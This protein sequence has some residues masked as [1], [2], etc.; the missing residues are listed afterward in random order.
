MRKTKSVSDAISL[1]N[2][3]VRAT[4]ESN[5]QIFRDTPAYSFLEQYNSLGRFLE[6][7]SYSCAPEDLIADP[8]EFLPVSKRSEPTHG[9][10]YGSGYSGKNKAVYF[11][12]VDANISAK[13]LTSIVRPCLYAALSNH[14]ILLIARKRDNAIGS[15]I[16][17]KVFPKMDV[18]TT[19]FADVS[20]VGDAVSW[21]NDHKNTVLITGLPILEELR[22]AC[23]EREVSVDD[24][25]IEA[26]LVGGS[27][28][29]DSALTRAQQ[30][31]PAPVR[32]VY[33]FTEGRGIFAVQCPKCLSYRVVSDDNYLLELKRVEGLADAEGELLVTCCLGSNGTQL[34]RY[35]VGDLVRRSAKPC[36]SCP[37]GSERFIV[38]GRSDDVLVVGHL[39][40][41]WS[42]SVDR[43]IRDYIDTDMYCVRI[44]RSD[45]ER[46]IVEVV[47]PNYVKRNGLRSKIVSALSSINPDFKRQLE[48]EFFDFRLK[49]V[50][51]V[52]MSNYKVN[53]I[54]DERK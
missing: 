2:G 23:N 9:P 49:Y 7:S 41:Q 17:S 38:S 44:S 15:W 50:E 19:Q 31:F 40:V 27:I 11:D 14:N 28:I 42:E 22:K 16:H 47:L 51:E 20:D 46:D 24:L 43:K 52:P 29:T 36:T 21:L 35:Q 33:G 18:G 12:E 37:S 32:G 53:R 1:I 34:L 45:S 30:S 8:E 48:K 39:N 25:G 4:H 26:V 5:F 6:S 10:Y 3:P 54:I 13:I